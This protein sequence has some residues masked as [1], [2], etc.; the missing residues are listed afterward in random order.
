MPC[1]KDISVARCP[2]PSC[3]DP[4]SYRFSSPKIPTHWCSICRSAGFVAVNTPPCANTVTADYSR[5]SPSLIGFPAEHW[6][7]SW[8]MF[9][10]PARKPTPRGTGR[11]TSNRSNPDDWKFPFRA[12]ISPT[13]ACARRLV[14]IT[15]Y[16]SIAPAENETYSRPINGID[17]SH[18]PARRPRF[19]DILTVIE[20]HTALVRQR[21]VDPLRR[22]TARTSPSPP[23]SVTNL[24]LSDASPPADSLIHGRRS[25]SI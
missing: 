12:A 22:T 11:K 9:P 13:P 21:P 6:I 3:T 8:A 5:A 14:V 17:R 15:Y 1:R 24:R 25:L 2:K 18:R 20:S 4:T 23:P 7:I 10:A 19:N 16:H